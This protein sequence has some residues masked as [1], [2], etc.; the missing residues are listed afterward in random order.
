MMLGLDIGSTCGWST[1]WGQGEWKFTGDRERKLYA[2]QISVENFLDSHMNISSIIY[3][4]PFC[5]GLAATRML[6]G[7]AG[8]VE[9][10]AYEKSI[11][12]VDMPPSTFK[13]WFTGNG[14][15]S[16]EDMIAEVNKRGFTVLSTCE[17]AADAVAVR[18]YGE[19]HII[20]G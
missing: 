1:P 6:W 20:R 3:E 17:H 5:R 16:K 7:M 12:C 14:R 10:A 2:L 11:P 13:K 19:A 15:A 4:R 18:L 8:V 9:A